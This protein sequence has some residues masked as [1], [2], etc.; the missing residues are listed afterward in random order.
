[1]AEVKAGLPQSALKPITDSGVAEADEKYR[2]A[3]DY[4]TQALLAREGN[5][6]QQQLLAIS[7]GLLTPGPT[8]SFGESV[9]HAAGNV[10]KVQKE[11]EAAGLENAKMRLQLAQAEREMAQRT[12]AAGAFRGL[13]GG[14]RPGAAPSG[15]PA[16]PGAAP[17][18]PG[19]GGA[20]GQQVQNI[21]L[22]DALAFAAAF[23]EQ[24]ELAKTLMDAAKFNSERYK[25]AMNGTVFDTMT[26]Q[27]IAQIPPGQTASSY[28]LPEIGG[29]QLMTP[30]Q[31]SS[32]QAARE[33]GLGRQWVKDFMSTEGPKAATKEPPK[34]LTQADVEAEA[35]GAK[36]KATKTAA[37]EVDRTQQTI[38]A[39][40]GA[41]TRITHYKTMEGFANKPGVAELLG[42]F[43]RPD[44]LA[45]AGKFIEEGRFGVPQ[46]REILSNLGAP[47]DVINNLNVLSSLAAQTS[48]EFSKSY[49][50]GQGAV[51]DFER[52]LY[53]SLGPTIKDPLEAFMMKSK[54]LTAKAEYERDLA[55]ALRRSKKS[56]DDFQ[57]TDPNYQKILDSYQ[58]KAYEVAGIKQPAAAPAGPITSADVQARRDAAKQRL[59]V[60]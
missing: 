28:F 47:Q 59:G 32:Y 14:Q 12:Q 16:A 13:V 30:G 46:M 11:Q 24:K 29:N 2:N 37:A 36:E 40:R 45:A 25:I 41:N 22:Q 10:L 23:P 35:A 21:T 19:E 60:K 56:L 20:S 26:G 54:L 49:G 6:Q 7:Q 4:I 5:N 9:G 48:I 51:S 44:F 8:G 43:E 58:R 42:Y 34:I 38:E 33:K 1:M 55:N 3:L 17:A 39:G 18:T 27:Y 52:R 31:Y 53:A 57:D 50:K 15:A